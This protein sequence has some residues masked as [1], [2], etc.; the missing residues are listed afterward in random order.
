ML[1]AMRYS[2]AGRLYNGCCMRMRDFLIIWLV[3]CAAG[4]TFAQG[5][6]K[7]PR[8]ADGHPDFQGFWENDIATPLQRPTEIANRPTLTNAEVEKMKQKAK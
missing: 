2:D 1:N 5:Q 7:A 4:L 3:I 8:T 6:Y